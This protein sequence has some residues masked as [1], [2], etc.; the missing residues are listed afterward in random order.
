MNS[1][2]ADSGANSDEA[3]GCRP[4]RPKESA[5][6]VRDG[7]HTTN[8]SCVGAREAL[9]LASHSGPGIKAGIV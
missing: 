4:A 8:S 6:V 2:T 5:A 1:Q 7:V 3:S 9:S